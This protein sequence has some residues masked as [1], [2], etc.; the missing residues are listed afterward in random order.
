MVNETI[1]KEIKFPKAMSTPMTVF[2]IG[3]FGGVFWTIIGYFAYLFSFTELRPNI[4]L[5]PWALGDWKRDWL[6]TAISIIII[7]LFSVGAA[8]V[9]YGM[10][11][12]LKGI[13]PG[14]IYG[15]VIFLLVFIVLNP[16]FPSMDPFLKLDRDTLVTSACLYIVYGVFIGYSIS[17][18]SQNQKVQDKEP[19]S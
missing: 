7:G 5:E 12:K 15:I 1:E 17:Y 4:I 19:V 9:Y 6:G 18:E 3:L 11:K 8:F 14:F 10:L 16:L 2:W 13:W